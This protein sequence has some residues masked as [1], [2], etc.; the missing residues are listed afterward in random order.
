MKQKLE[1]MFGYRAYSIRNGSGARRMGLVSSC[2]D[3]S[4]LNL[5]CIM[6]AIGNHRMFWNRALT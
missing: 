1:S 3:I 4:Y 5:N 6:L 2:N